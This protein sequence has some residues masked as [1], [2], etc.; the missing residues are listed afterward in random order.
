MQLIST[1]LSFLFCLSVIYGALCDL[2]RYKIPNTVSYGLALLFIPFAA[3]NWNQLPILLHLGI[4]ALVFVLCVIFWQLKWMGGGDVKFMSAL[5]LWMGP[6]KILFFLILLSGFSALLVTV[7]RFMIQSNDY[8]QAGNYPAVFKTLLQK[9]SE[10]A[11]PYGLPSGAA[12]LIAYLVPL[13]I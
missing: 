7:L 11:I 3:L 13:S 6:D 5:S 8:Y 10:K 12:A 2:T 9:A 1:A 4:F